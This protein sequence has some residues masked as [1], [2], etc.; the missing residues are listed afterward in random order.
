MQQLIEKITSIAEEANET[1]DQRADRLTDAA[2]AANVDPVTLM[3]VEEDIRGVG[4]LAAERN[5]EK[6]AQAEQQLTAFAPMLGVDPEATEDLS[7][8]T[9]IKLIG[10]FAVERPGAAAL[11]VRTLHES[12]SR[13][14]LYQELNTETPSPGALKEPVDVGGGE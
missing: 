6:V 3:D 8:E 7:A 10:Q 12:F 9:F 2:A 14:G 1:D 11:T 5:S 4:R 13:H